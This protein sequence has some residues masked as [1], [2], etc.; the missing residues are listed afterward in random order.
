MPRRLPTVAASLLALAVLGAGADKA[1]ASYSGT[2]QAGTVTLTGDSASDKLALRL[3]PGAPDI[4]EADV[5][6][7]GTPD[8]LFD[9]STFTAVNVDAGGGD[10]ELR[11]DRSGGIFTDEQVTLNGGPGADT[12]SGDVGNDVL[13]GGSGNDVVDGNIGADTIR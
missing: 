6:D 4:L 7:D 11:I 8:L 5:G 12:L 9:R 13:I 2:L 1:A 10:D 3:R